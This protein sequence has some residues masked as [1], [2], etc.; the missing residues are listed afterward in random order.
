MI[1]DIK[2]GIDISYNLSRIESIVETAHELNAFTT[3]IVNDLPPPD[4]I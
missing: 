2:P 3:L 4:S 1:A